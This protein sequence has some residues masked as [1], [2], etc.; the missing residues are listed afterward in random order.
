M[1]RAFT[2]LEVM[3][4]LALILIVGGLTGWKMHEA[5]C[6]KRFQSELSRLQSRIMTCHRLAAAMQC[7]WKGVLIK[8]GTGWIFETICI[9]SPESKK[10]KPLQLHSFDLF[11]NGKKIHELEIEFFSSGQIDPE[12]TF[13]FVADGQ[14]T[15]WNFPELFLKESSASSKKIG[16]LSPAMMEK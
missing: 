11:L 8:E 10:L 3:V 1:K 5:V 9:E 13:L 7:D 6:K 16:P 12:G 2:L 4:A 15:A 14:K